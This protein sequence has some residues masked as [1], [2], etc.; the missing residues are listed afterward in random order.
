MQDSIWQS[1]LAAF[2]DHVAAVQPGPAA[3]SASAVAGGLGLG[4]LIKVLDIVRR[5]KSFTGDLE[6][7]TALIDAA[8][9]E[10][11]NLREAA[12]ADIVALHESGGNPFAAKSVIEV[13][14][15]AAR[16]AGAGVDL[17]ASAAA[18]IHGPPAAD[19]GSAVLLL[20]ASLRATLL[21][22]E[23]N[24]RP[25]PQDEE[26]VISTN[27]ESKDLQDRALQ[28]VD[29]VLRQISRESDSQES[30]K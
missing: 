25:L 30:G 18:L 9:H 4:L 13:P 26:F 19:L 8:R 12:D 29:E 3:V 2:C 22:V 27:A 23:F 16:A 10:S 14:M 15:A 7:V 21:C 28:Q 24:V 6:A 5:R 1:T 20:S 11:L 17:C